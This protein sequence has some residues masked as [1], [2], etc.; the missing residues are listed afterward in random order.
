MKK[1]IVF[2]TALAYLTLSLAGQIFSPAAASPPLDSKTQLKE[3]TLNK[4]AKTSKSPD[5]NTVPFTHENHSTKNYSEDLKSVPSCVVCH[6]TDQPKDK[7]TGVLKTSERAEVLTTEALA[8]PDSAVV[9]GC[10]TCHAQTDVKPSGWPANPVVE[11]EDEGE[12]TLNN[13]EAYHRNCITCHEAV[14]KIK[15]D[16]TAVTT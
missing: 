11:Y 9:K 16:T 2:A 8:K 3:Y 13:E 12:V 14:K 7:L 4:D 1:T 5:K 10:R 15:A 6:H